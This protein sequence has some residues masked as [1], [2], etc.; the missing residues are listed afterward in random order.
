M[1]R[2]FFLPLIGVLVVPWL[3]AAGEAPRRV[4]VEIVRLVPLHPALTVAGSVQA[5]V[6]ADL[7]F[8]VAGKVT[9]RP[10]EIGDRVHPGQLLAKLD[11]TDLQNNLEVAAA[12]LESA[13]A[14]AAN[15]QSDLHRYDGLG[16]NSP[17]YLPSEYD[18]RLAASRTAAARVV[19]AQRQLALARDQRGYGDLTADAEGIVTSLP[20]QTGQVVSAGQTVATVAHTDAIEVVADVPE[21]RLG[22]IRA[23]GDVGITLWALP[24][25]TLHGRVREI[26][27]LADPASR[28]FAV[29]V[30]VK[31]AAQE[32]LSLGMTAALVFGMDGPE[33]VMLPASAISDIGGKPAVWVLD[34]AAQTAGL[35]PV[36]VALYDGAGHVVV[37][38]GLKQGE[39]VITAG[40][41]QITPGMRLVAWEGASR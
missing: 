31:D 36:D 39:Q 30:A 4:R 9:Q 13:Q 38:A 2:R 40:V 37:S 33:G 12:A 11:P 16:R 17:A 32:R 10:V 28:T 15:T 29:K 18:H 27:A 20:V 34:P 8:R 35:R 25:V 6:Q 24:G 3:V 19:Q 41:Q 23:A 26:G 21:N 7:A 1:M 14:D 5:R 22:E